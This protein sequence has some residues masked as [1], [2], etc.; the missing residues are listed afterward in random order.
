MIHNLHIETY[1]QGKTIVLLHGWGMHS[2]LMRA[3]AMR[4]AKHARVICVDLPGHGR[5]GLEQ[6]FELQAIATE[7]LFALEEAPCCWLG[8]SLGALVALEVARQCP[9][10]VSSL[11]ILAGT[12]CFIQK[13]AWIGME[14][15]LLDNFAERLTLNPKVTA[16]TFMALQ[17]QGMDNSSQLLQALKSSLSECSPPNHH[18]LQAGL[19][20]LKQQDLRLVMAALKCPVLAIL[21]KRDALVPVAVANHLPAVLETVQIAIIDAAGHIPFISHPEETAKV[22]I[23]F[24]TST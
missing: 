1:G 5:S 24:I 9:E 14:G 11:V 23:K 16:L 6:P 13:P 3:F 8:W 15:K 17:I 2:G 19:L 7:L 22:L 10:R 21:G 20:I 18:T 4:L 12:P